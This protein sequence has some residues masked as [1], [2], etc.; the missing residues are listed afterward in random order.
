MK[1]KNGE[2]QALKKPGISARPVAFMVSSFIVLAIYVILQAVLNIVFT[3]I[4]TNLY[5]NSI[6]AVIT[7]AASA[8]VSNSYILEYL[9]L[10]FAGIIFLKDKT[11]GLIFSGI[12]YILRNL[13]VSNVTSLITTP[14]EEF[15]SGSKTSIGLSSLIISFGSYILTFLLSGI[16]FAS[17]MKY[18][19]SSDPAVINKSKTPKAIILSVLLV[20]LPVVECIFHYIYVYLL[21]PFMQNKIP[22]ISSSNT[23]HSLTWDIL[24]CMPVLMIVVA[25]I[26]YLKVFKDK[27]SVFTAVGCLTIANSFCFGI[28]Y[29]ASDILYG[30]G[31]YYFFSNLLNIDNYYDVCNIVLIVLR[32][33]ATILTSIT[34]TILFLIIYSVHTRKRK[35]RKKK[36]D[37]EKETNGISEQDVVNDSVTAE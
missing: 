24:S 27:T 6:W 26:V 7:N 16:I 21:N 4:L 23:L 22:F 36:N 33:L 34:A 11:S 14:T 15:I 31:S 28:Y 35:N 37:E 30:Y 19:R 18:K 8:F 25:L 2:T 1:K 9:I 17:V 12:F 13:I 29:I 10:I 5:A 32:I 20:L 3:A